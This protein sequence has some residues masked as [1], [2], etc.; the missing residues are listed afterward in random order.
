MNKLN[1][2]CEMVEKNGLQFEMIGCRIAA[3]IL[4][5]GGCCYGKR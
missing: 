4:F 2:L 5:F 1:I 3:V